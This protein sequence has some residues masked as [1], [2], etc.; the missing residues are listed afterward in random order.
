[1][2]RR[3]R[4]QSGYSLGEILIVLALIGMTIAIVSPAWRAL[5]NKLAVRAADKEIRALSPRSLSRDRKGAKR[6]HQVQKR[7]NRVDV[8]DL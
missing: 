8:C 1:M 5:T 6:R 2:R 3:L 4:R 7:G